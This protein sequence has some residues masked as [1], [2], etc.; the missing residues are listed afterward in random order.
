M[1]LPDGFRWTRRWQY[2]KC[3]DA[4]ALDGEQ[5]AVLLDRV[6]GGWSA[7][8]ECQ[9]AGVRAPLVLRR[10]SSYESGKRGCELWA[11]RHEA[12]LRSEVGEVIRNR[13]VPVGGG[14]FATPL[15]RPPRCSS[16]G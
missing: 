14:H 2:S 8:L 6:D 7:R 16:D 1:T 3:D 4:L 11:A 9:R 13:P 15:S 10:C 5:V 12:R